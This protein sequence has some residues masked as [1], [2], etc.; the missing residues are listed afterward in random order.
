MPRDAWN[1]SRMETAGCPTHS[2]FCRHTHSAS[3]QNAQASDRMLDDDVHN[4]QANNRMLEDDAAHA[5]ADLQRLR[6]LSRTAAQLAAAEAARLRRHTAALQARPRPAAGSRLDPAAC[7]VSQA[8]QTARARSDF[9]CAVWTLQP[10]CSTSKVPAAQAAR[11]AQEEAQAAQSLGVLRTALAGQEAANADRAARSAA[12]AASL[13]TLQA[14]PACYYVCSCD[15]A[16]S[17]AERLLRLPAGAAGGHGPAARGG[18][19]EPGREAGGRLRGGQAGCGRRWQRACPACQGMPRRLGTWSPM[20]RA[21][22]P[23][24]SHGLQ[25]VAA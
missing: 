12:S 11:H 15:Q 5:E 1:N 10:C 8:A 23:T 20:L 14:R 13:S 2:C 18:A 9:H 16:D 7:F 25:A 21:P 22:Q 17:R 24:V 6:T 4:A 3:M 19:A